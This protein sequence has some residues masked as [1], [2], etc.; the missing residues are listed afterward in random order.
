MLKKTFRIP[1]M[2]CANC[3]THLEALE[4]EIAG[5]LTIQGSYQKQSLVVEYDETITDEALICNAIEK[6]GYIAE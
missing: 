5:I 3:V 6:L 2:F 4:D 1:D